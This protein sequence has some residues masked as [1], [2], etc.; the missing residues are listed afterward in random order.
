VAWIIPDVDGGV[1][2]VID[3]D[4]NNQPV[5]TIRHRVEVGG[6][7]SS[8]AGRAD[9]ALVLA[10]CEDFVD[11]DCLASAGWVSDPATGDVIVE[12]PLEAGAKLGG[13]DLAG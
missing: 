12:F 11:G 2:E 4:N 8:L 6:F 13:Y 1:L 3:L 5:S 9:G 7:G 10:T